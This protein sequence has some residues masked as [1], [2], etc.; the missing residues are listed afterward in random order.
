MNHHQPKIFVGDYDGIAHGRWDIPYDVDVDKWHPWEKVT[1][2]SCFFLFTNEKISLEILQIGYGTVG[3]LVNKEPVDQNAKQNF[4]GTLTRNCWKWGGV[5]HHV[6][7]SFFGCVCG[8]VF[9]NKSTGKMKIRD[10][11]IKHE[12]KSS[13]LEKKRNNLSLPLH[14]LC[15]QI[16]YGVK[17]SYA[18]KQLQQTMQ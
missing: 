6:T 2:C 13:Q 3:G 8:Y 11:K 17:E 7:D 5:I 16:L 15:Q 1:P 10:G 9:T 18:W 12:L 14:A 4:E